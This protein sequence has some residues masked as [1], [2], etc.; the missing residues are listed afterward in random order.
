MLRAT[1]CLKCCLSLLPLGFRIEFKMLIFAPNPHG[2][3][4]ARKSGS[5]K[6]GLTSQAKHPFSSHMDP[7]IRCQLPNSARSSVDLLQQLCLVLLRR[8]RAVGC[9]GRVGT[10]ALGSA[11][12]TESWGG[13]K[14]EPGGS[15]WRD[16]PVCHWGAGQGQYLAWEALGSRHRN[17]F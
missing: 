7:R 12:L 17:W 2:L 5:V 13:Q 3:V 4:L 14:G 8:A 10:G 16:S 9:W 15:S 6:V 11:S 1:T